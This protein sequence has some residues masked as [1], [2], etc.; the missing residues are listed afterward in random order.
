M[1][2]E[3][4]KHVQKIIASIKENAKPI[5]NTIKKRP[6]YVE[7]FYVTK[8]FAK[9]FEALSKKIDAHGFCSYCD[10]KQENLSIYEIARELEKNVKYNDDDYSAKKIKKDANLAKRLVL[11]FYDEYLPNKAKEVEQI[12]KNE[13][14]LF[15]DEKNKSHVKIKKVYF[16]KQ[17]NSF[18]GT[19]DGHKFLSF[20]VTIDGTIADW[21]TLAHE[22]SHAVSSS[23]QQYLKHFKRSRY[24]IRFDRE[25][26]SEIESLITENLFV[27][28]LFKKGKITQE[29]VDG[30]NNANIDSLVFETNVIREEQDVIKQLPLPV[31]FKSL[32]DLVTKL[33]QEG[34]MR[35]VS[36]I[37]KMNKS[38][39]RRGY[40]LF[41]YFVGRIVADEW[42]CKFKASTPE[43]QKQILGNFEQYLEKNERFGLN[44]ACEFLLGQ[45]F[46][47]I[48]LSFIERHKKQSAN[49]NKVLNYIEEQKNGA[50]EE[51]VVK[52]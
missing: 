5:V 25:A 6:F 12:F 16:Y 28:F 31:D 30:I 11:S 52:K 34:K 40:Y 38:E 1:K 36:R 49:D 44:S 39:S 19:Q 51:I 46:E 48:A 23:M 26:I 42:F 18:V 22:S 4:K 20:Q 27:D 33:K 17:Q 41:R 15:K 14:P 37:Q 13:H 47:N 7:D 24:D 9:E 45:N 10:Q 35:L 8:K 21:I 2:E 43:E 3:T 29:D 50:V 32:D